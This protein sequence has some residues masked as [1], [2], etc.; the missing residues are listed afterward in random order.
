MA[1]NESGR[2]SPW[3]SMVW[4]S[5]AGR[6]S[7]Q[8]FRCVRS[9]SRNRRDD[10]RGDA[11]MA[12]FWKLF[13][14]A[15]LVVAET[16]KATDKSLK[17]SCSSCGGHIKFAVQNLGQRIACPHC[18]TAITLRQPENLKMSCFFCKGHIE[19]PSHALGQ[20]NRV[21]ALRENNHAVK[22]CLK[23]FKTRL[24]CIF[25]GANFYLVRP[26]TRAYVR[27][28]IT[29][30]N[31]SSQPVLCIELMSL[32][33]IFSGYSH[34]PAQP[35]SASRSGGLSQKA[36]LAQF[37]QKV[38]PILKD[39]C[40]DC[41]GDGESRADVAFDTL[42]NE[43]QI[44]NNPEFWLNVLEKYPRA[45]CLCQ[46]HPR[47]PPEKTTNPRPTDRVRGVWR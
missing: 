9:F 21:S 37:H 19:F 18:Q 43:E 45:S 34:Q 1:G 12:G 25:T 20:K 27:A 42:T 35:A 26:F 31:Y 22:P 16:S 11:G 39:N 4:G 15:V 44:L 2:L 47:L 17:M 5:H 6:L 8:L 28:S 32:I 24:N 23:F 36:A 29:I 40:Y 10:G 41:H 14:V 33:G 46:K 7:R 3:M 13:H 30:E 38:E